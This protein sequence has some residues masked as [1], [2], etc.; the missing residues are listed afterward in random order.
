MEAQ[1]LG[2]VRGAER[3]TPSELSPLPLVQTPALLDF[4]FGYLFP[5]PPQ[6][7]AHRTIPHRRG[8][9][10]RSQL[11]DLPS[12]ALKGRGG[13]ESSLAVAV[14]EEVA[15]EHHLPAA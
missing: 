2:A 5:T 11:V 1:L 12:V 6:M 10:P 9:S 3:N 14:D 4:L 15:I 13:P 7:V 8:K